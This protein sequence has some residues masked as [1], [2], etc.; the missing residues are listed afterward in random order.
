MNDMRFLRQQ[1]V[2]DA[3]K[4][5][6]LQVTLIGLGSI[7]SVTGLYLAKMG[8]CNLTC[9]D[10]DVVDIHNVSNQ[11]YGMSD[12]GLLKADAFSI[13]VENQT[14]VLPNTIGMQYDGRELTGVVISAVDS[15][16]SRETIWKLVREKPEVKL[17]LDA[18]MGL[19]TLVVYAVRPQVRED[20]IAYSQT[21]CNDS[22]A[23]QEPCTARTICY[24]PLMAASVICS[25]VKRYVCDEMLPARIVLD[26]ATMTLL[27]GQ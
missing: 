13:L 19:E 1:D 16:K 11:A 17:Y 14:G 8:V 22:D 18:R 5:A 6:N 27:A 15:M 4:L 20:R 23:L 12:V 25:L 26:L 7:G 3:E 9:F 24:T 10:A 21:I 2:V